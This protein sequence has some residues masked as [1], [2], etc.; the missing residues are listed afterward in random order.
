MLRRLVVGHTHTSVPHANTP[1]LPCEH[2]STTYEHG[3]TAYAHVSPAQEMNDVSVQSVLRKR[4]RFFD[5]AADKQIRGGGSKPGSEHV[6]LSAMG[7][8]GKV[9][10]CAVASAFSLASSSSKT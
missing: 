9:E 10:G 4:D 7:W 8:E 5:F 3:S 6:N 2:A 1:V